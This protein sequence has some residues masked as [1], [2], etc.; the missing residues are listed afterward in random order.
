VLGWR[1]LAEMLH[2]PLGVVGFVFA[3]AAGLAILRRFGRPLDPVS[4]QAAEEAPLAP[5]RPT[6]LAPVLGI[7]LVGLGLLYA[8]KPEPASAAQREWSFSEP[9]AT[10]EWPLSP[11]ELAWLSSGGPVSAQRYRFE[12]KGMQGSLLLVASQDWRDQHRPE[13]CFTVY[14]LEVQGSQPALAAP[15]FPLRLLD[16]GVPGGPQFYS[17]AY[18]LQSPS[19]VTADY[20]ARIWDDLAPHPEPWVLVTVLYD[21]SV[22]PGDKTA[23]E[24]YTTL[25][26]S[27]QEGLLK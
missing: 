4:T 25:R 20:A 7:A 5:A 27:V 18:W 22:N 26:Q 21:E 15:N 3:C 1:L 10:E 14:G 11:N 2:L 16:L 19:Q 8:P 9:L 6:W 17:A 12:W 13:R 24:L 23:L